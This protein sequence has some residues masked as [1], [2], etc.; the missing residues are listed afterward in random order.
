MESTKEIYRKIIDC[1]KTSYYIKEFEIKINRNEH[2]RILFTEKENFESLK[3]KLFYDEEYL[4]TKCYPIKGVDYYWM[5]ELVE[6]ILN[7]KEICDLNNM[8]EM[9]R[10]NLSVIQI[11]LFSMNHSYP[12]IT[13][14]REGERVRIF[15]AMNHLLKGLNKRIIIFIENFQWIDDISFEFFKYFVLKCMNFKGLFVVSGNYKDKRFEELEK[16]ITIEKM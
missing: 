4:Y 1:E 13:S 3:E 2:V 12:I 11:E 15:S 9:I 8:P 14:S 16:F 7:K 6:E 5:S 10:E